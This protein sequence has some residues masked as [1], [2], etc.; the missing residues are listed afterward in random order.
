MYTYMYIYVHVC[1]C[2][3]IYVHSCTYMYISVQS[4]TYMHTQICPPGLV[5]TLFDGVA[6]RASVPRLQRTLKTSP[7]GKPHLEHLSHGF[8]ENH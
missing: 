7:R 4:C 3:Y 6:P 5:Q 2:V 8:C 1:T